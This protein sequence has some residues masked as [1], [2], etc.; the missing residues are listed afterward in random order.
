MIWTVR[1]LFHCWT[2]Y[3]EHHTYIH[4]QICYNVPNRGTLGTY[5]IHKFVHK[6]TLFRHN[7]VVRNIYEQDL[8]IVQV[9]WGIGF[10]NEAACTLLME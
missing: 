1:G 7:N 8:C 2:I 9:L 5:V 4:M 6:I 3:V 10:H